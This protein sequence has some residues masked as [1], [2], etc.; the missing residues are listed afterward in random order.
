MTTES[1]FLF[2][3][4]LLGLLIIVFLG[5]QNKVEPFTGTFSGNFNSTDNT[6]GETNSQTSS[7]SDTNFDNYNHFSGTSSTLMNG[8]TFYGDNGGSIVVSVNNDGTTTLKVI[9]KSGETAVVYKTNG[10][11]NQ[12]VQSFTGPNGGEATIINYRGQTA[13]L[14]TTSTGEYL[15]TT[16][17]TQNTAGSTSDSSSSAYNPNYTTYN[18]TPNTYYGS[19]GDVYSPSSFSNDAYTNPVTYYGPNGS[20]ALIN[21]SGPN[22]LTVNSNNSKIVY[23][24]IPDSTGYVSKYQGPDQAN[25]IIIDTNGTKSIQVT[26][27]GRTTIYKAS[28]QQQPQQSSSQSSDQTNMMK[29][30]MGMLSQYQSQNQSQPQSQSQNSQTSQQSYNSAFP[31]GISRNQ[32]P[33]GQED[34]Y[35]LKSEIVPPVCPA[36]PA[37][38]SCPRQEKCPPCPACA[39]CPEPSFEC[40]KVPN[41]NAVSNDYLPVPVLSD[42]SSFGM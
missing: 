18:N 34:L 13:I 38:A 7:S 28:S 21:Y 25:A 31:S 30:L 14:L 17:E 29:S 6:T 3:I 4:L 8:S 1:F 9:M 36:C 15:F 39:R 27:N 35:I 26:Y 2:I 5:I 42:F 24:G 11:S 33:P 16:S 40:K 10:N 22:T 37:A 19:T 32:I 23:T 41:Y 20:T 12:N